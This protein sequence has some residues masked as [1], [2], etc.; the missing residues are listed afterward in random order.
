MERAPSVILEEESR[1][2]FIALLPAAWIHR[3]EN[4]DYHLDMQI[5]VV[6][7]GKLTNQVFWVQVKA[8]ENIAHYNEIVPCSIE[9][10]HLKH[11]E[12]CRLP[13]VILLWVKPENT[14]YY[15]FAQQ[16]IR[17][18]LSREDPNWR[19]KEEK[20]IKFP[21]NSR[22]R[23][24]GQLKSIANDGYLYIIPRELNSASGAGL[25]VPPWLD[26]IPESNDE[27]LKERMAR[28]LL[29]MRKEDYNGAIAEFEFILRV[30]CKTPSTERMSIL[31]NLGNAHY[32]LGHN[33]EALKN[34]NAVLELAKD[35]IEKDA[36][37]GKA[38]ALGNIGVVYDDMGDLENA[39]KCHQ[40]ALK[41]FREF[42]DRFGEASQL[43]SI[44]RVYKDKGDLGNALKYLQEALEIDREIG[45]KVG[46]ANQL[47]N[48]GLIYN[49]KGDLDSALKCQQDALKIYVEFDYRLG[50]ASMSCNIGVIY[51]L[52]GDLDNALKHVQE[53]LKIHREIGSRLGEAADLGNIALINLGRGDFDIALKYGQDALKIN[54]GIEYRLGEAGDL[55]YIAMIYLAKDDPDNALKYLQEAKKILDKY[56]LAYDK[57]TLQE[58][59]NLIAKRK[60]S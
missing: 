5:T 58:T 2:A 24:A 25:V 34:Y 35:T 29:C 38:S 18:K 10:R 3:D 47:G 41:I 13:V 33:T 11:Y 28:A 52:K 59:M 12:S 39:F 54:R 45:Y 20:T 49:S 53:A 6:E 7:D 57:D 17:E 40:E 27:L 15:L 22:L 4:P 14:F 44:A 9:T 36:L 23:D 60:S 46:E 50:I 37:V 30:V 16:Y 48:I 19:I 42:G 32:S 31:L 56:G 43:S 21:A 1:R 51:R 8:T 55:H 26:G